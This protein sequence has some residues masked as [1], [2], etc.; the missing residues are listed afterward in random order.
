MIIRE[1]IKPFL[2][3]IIIIDKKKL[4]YILFCDIRSDQIKCL[5]LS[6]SSQ[7]SASGLLNGAIS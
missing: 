6:K 2:Q 1:Y 3:Q 4:N 5:K 7:P